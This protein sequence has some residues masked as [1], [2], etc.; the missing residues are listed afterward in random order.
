MRE[1]QRG[2][3]LKLRAIGGLHVV[4]LAWDFTEGRSNAK[5]C[6]AL[7]TAPN[8]FPGGFS[9]ALEFNSSRNVDRSQH[10]G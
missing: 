9:W 8:S 2:P 3:V 4:T 5:A 7:R 1:L 10:S 6:L